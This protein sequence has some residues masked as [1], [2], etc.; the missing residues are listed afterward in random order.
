MVKLFVLLNFRF[1]GVKVFDT[2]SKALCPDWKSIH[3]C[4]YN[5]FFYKNQHNLRTKAFFS[6]KKQNK[7][8]KRL[9]FF[10]KNHFATLLLYE[11]FSFY[12]LK[13]S[14]LLGKGKLNLRTSTRLFKSVKNILVFNEAF[15]K[16]VLVLIK[17][18][19]LNFFKK[20]HEPFG[21]SLC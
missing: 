11:A 14:R 2:F 19:V 10:D 13:I 3:S 21:Q 8:Q 5:S 4:A 9:Y 20:T 1:L 17:K 12:S 6:L 18:S 16:N 7:D 15:S